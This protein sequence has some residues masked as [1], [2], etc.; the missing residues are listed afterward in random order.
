MFKWIRYEGCLY[1]IP[2]TRMYS[3]IAAFDLDGTLVFTASGRKP[4]QINSPDDWVMP[5]SVLATLIEVSEDSNVVIFTNQSIFTDVIKRKL[6]NIVTYLKS[7]GVDPYIFVATGH[8][9]YRKPDGGMFKLFE[10]VHP[11]EFEY[12]FYC[13]DA[14]GNTDYPPYNWSDSDRKFAT[15]SN[16]AFYEPREIFEEDY[17]CIFY[18]DT[19]RLTILM[20]NPGSGKST[21]AS[22]IKN[23]VILSSDKIK[24]KK[25]LMT[26]FEKAVEEGKNIVIDR[27]N[28]SLAD[29][30]EFET[31]VEGYHIL[32][33]WVV[34]DGRFSNELREDP[35]PEAAY[36][37]Y[38]KKFV[39]PSEEEGD[40]CIISYVKEGEK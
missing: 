38:S 31:L 6:E 30:M 22:N 5:P 17:E 25:K 20:G 27:T 39:R 40:I 28:A 29:R 8:D 9:E 7:K 10:K 24:T 26:L 15:N 11:E 3:K 21:I 35:V 36:A 19:K 4:F 16:L 18:P 34:I 37:T 13:G 23:S 33:V 14:A 12:I 1:H 2:V 32:I